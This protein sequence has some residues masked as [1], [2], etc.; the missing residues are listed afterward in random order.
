[1]ADPRLVHVVAMARNR[2]IGR[3]GEMPW[4]LPRDLQWF[5]ACTLGKPVIMGRKTFQSIGRPL[6]RRMNIV[7]S[8]D[9]AFRPR[10]VFTAQTIEDAIEKARAH[11]FADDILP[12]ICIIGGGEIYRQT[13]GLVSRLYLTEIEAEIEGDTVYPDFDPEDWRCEI[14]AE[15]PADARN[16]QACRFMIFDRLGGSVNDAEG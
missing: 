9:P 5:K 3:D 15:T 6:P 16:S 13:H 7:V 1:M 14:V 10:D 11:P 12:E 8:R 4:R 2:V